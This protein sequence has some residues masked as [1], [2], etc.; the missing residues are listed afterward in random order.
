MSR[1][2]C[3]SCF[4]QSLH[5]RKILSRPRGGGGSSAQHSPLQ[6]P[7]DP[8]PVVLWISVSK[9]TLHYFVEPL[10]G[11]KELQLH[12]SSVPLC[13]G[14]HVPF[15]QPVGKPLHVR[16]GLVQEQKQSSLLHCRTMPPLLSVMKLPARNT[17]DWK[18][19]DHWLL[20]KDKDNAR[21]VKHL[22]FN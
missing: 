14:T 8:R 7:A 16:R 9:E 20:G 5:I 3:I 21:E 1:R 10:W 17:G 19:L 2:A 6:A 11:S 22:I 13:F 18:R 15:S 12:D 4:L